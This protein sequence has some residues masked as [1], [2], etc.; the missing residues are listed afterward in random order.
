M[1]ILRNK[2]IANAKNI[3]WGRKVPHKMVIFESDDWG[4]NRIASVDDYKNL[5]RAGILSEKS[6][7]YDKCDT[8]AKAKDLE[9]LFETLSSVKDINGKHAVFTNFFSPTNPDFEK[10]K[11]GDFRTYHYETFL[12]T[13]AK[14]GEEK[15]VSSLWKQGIDAGMIVPAYH[16]REHLTVPLWMQYLQQN[17]EK[18]REA[19]KYNFY[20]VQVASL[21]AV[22]QAFRPSLFFKDEAQKKY[23]GESLKDGLDVMEKIFH[24]RPTVFCPPNGISHPYFDKLLSTEGVKS[25]KTNPRRIEPDGNGGLGMRKF[26]N[27]DKNTFGQKFYFRNVW[28]EPYQMRNNAVDFCMSQIEG[29]FNW[30]KPAIICSHRVSYIGAIYPRNRENGI[31]QLQVLLKRIVKKWPD[32]VFA[33]SEHYSKILHNTQ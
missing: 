32:V 2:L 26:S 11:A 22:A 8:I 15:A 23:I 28:F 1:S 30:N 13:L 12:E 4:S 25:I 16:S 19:F 18:V 27:P 24:A 9:I 5:V 14:T 33:S 10:I 17:D 7:V 6:S 3:I 21:P 29:A 31:H 20:A